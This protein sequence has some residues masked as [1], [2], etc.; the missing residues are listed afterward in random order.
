MPHIREMNAVLGELLD[1]VGSLAVIGPTGA[2]FVRAGAQCPHFLR[3]VVGELDDAE[4]FAV[5]SSSAAI[6][7]WLTVKQRCSVIE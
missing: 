3:V 7:I 6:S 4:L 2:Q 5:A 1:D